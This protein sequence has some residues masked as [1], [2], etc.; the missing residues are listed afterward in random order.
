MIPVHLVINGPY[1]LA[2]WRIGG[3]LKGKSLGRRDTVSEQ[4]ALRRCEAIGSEIN[5]RGANITARIT[6]EAWLEEFLA[7]RPG[8]SHPT[9]HLYRL[10]ANRMVAFWGDKAQIG[11]VG[12]LD[13]LRFR[14][15][16]GKNPKL[17]A[18]TVYRICSEARAIFQ[19]A[20]DAE[21]LDK[22]PFAGALPAKPKPD[23]G[24][25]YVDLPTLNRLMD[26]A[27]PAWKVFL[28]LIRLAGLRQHE[29]L[30]LCDGPTSTS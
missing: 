29:A 1:W 15:W 10:C 16:L 9:A 4:D 22:N 25:Q 5:H 11:H 19:G 21:I 20:V 8:I 14:A 18:F 12:K 27:P 26:V 13:A 6:I 28:G 23:H 30:S 3:T 24:W 7:L 2:R 17:G